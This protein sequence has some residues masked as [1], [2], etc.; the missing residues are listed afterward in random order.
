MKTMRIIGISLI[1]MALLAIVPVTPGMADTFTVT[2][3]LPGENIHPDEAFDVTIQFTAPADSFNSV[4]V[5]DIA[6]PGW[7]VSVNTAWC[8]PSAMFSNTPVENKAEYV[9]FSSL[10]SGTVFTIKYRIS[11]PEDAPD[12]T[13]IFSAGK[14]VYYLAEAGPYTADITGDAVVTVTNPSGGGDSGGG[15][16]DNG[17]NNPGETAPDEHAND[18]SNPAI[19]SSTQ[20]EAGTETSGEPP[21]N[22][23]E[24]EGE[25]AEITAAGQNP[26]YTSII[27]PTA[28]AL[29]TSAQPV[30]KPQR[31]G[32]R[33]TSP[34]SSSISDYWQTIVIGIAGA[35]VIFLIVA[36]IVARRS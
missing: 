27:S 7:K 4:G 28:A 33:G 14:I 31:N 21:A 6:P 23:P 24:P 22:E 9:W 26:P 19:D 32:E 35:V 8:T 25:V 17:D 30:D 20:V 36:F 10:S 29:A 15:G 11:V 18:E 12:D 2:R 5:T 3:T 16:N 13:Y 1:L 34:A